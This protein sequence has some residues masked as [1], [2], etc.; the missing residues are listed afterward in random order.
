[1]RA[2]YV[3]T[4]DAST[5]INSPI[6]SGPFYA[7]REI[8]VVPNV[9]DDKNKIIVRLTEAYPKHGRIWINLYNN[10]WGNWEETGKDT[11][12]N[13]AT[14]SAV[15]G[16]SVKLYSNTEGGNLELTSPNGTV[17]NFDAYKNNYLR[18]FTGQGANSFK[19]QENGDFV[20]K[21]E[22]YDVH[23]NTLSIPGNIL[24]K[25]YAEIGND[26]TT[27]VASLALEKLSVSKA[28]LYIHYQITANDAN[29]NTY[30]FISLEKICSALGISSISNIVSAASKVELIQL[31]IQSG[32]SLNIEGAN[33]TIDQI[34][35]T[36]LLVSVSDN[37]Y[38]GIGRVYKDDGSFGAW[39]LSAGLYTVNSHGIITIHGIT[40][41]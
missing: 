34:G 3:G 39:P 37:K 6:S 25:N 29:S 4:E 41:E 12:T 31:F 9:Y 35:F 11:V 38:L 2:G 32:N 15:Y 27:V 8:L 21:V 30:N 40:Y 20:T 23:G 14:A 24:Y 18:I 33:C 5:L 22:I 17:W 13:A 16:G 1:M 26:H 36:G 7:Y 28:N 10:G 19:L